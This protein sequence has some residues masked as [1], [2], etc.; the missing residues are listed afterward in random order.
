MWKRH[1]GD[2]SH[3]APAPSKRLCSAGDAHQETERSKR[4]RSAI[5]GTADEFLC[6]ITQDLPMDPVTAEDGSVYERS[7]IT[8]W[9]AKQQCSPLTR[10]QM[11]TRLLPA[12]CVRN[13]IEQ[14]VR[15]GAIVGEK[16]ELWLKRLEDESVVAELRR[17]A[18][19]AGDV[20]AMY[21]LGNAFSMGTNG[22]DKS[23]TEGLRYYARGAALDDLPCMCVLGAANC[24]GVGDVVAKNEA[25]GV[26]YV[27][28]AAQAGDPV[29]CLML[30]KFFGMGHHGMPKDEIMAK[31]WINK[32]LSACRTQSDHVPDRAAYR[33]KWLYRR[34]I[35]EA[36][37]AQD[38]AKLV[39]LLSGL[40]AD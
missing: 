32:G 17:L 40:S 4:F 5:D 33:D 10:Q 15:S 18:D 12:T 22:L 27:S 39:L 14:L 1:A 19:E 37:L 34:L 23:A 24:A 2:G 35:D 6:P 9:L 11:G 26:H 25:L 36:K 20:S 3:E 29:G 38:T 16:A 31:R 30:G 13:A 21:Q 7:A 8:Q 28:V